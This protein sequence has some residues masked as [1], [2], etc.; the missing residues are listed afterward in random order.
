MIRSIAATMLLLAGCIAGPQPE[1]PTLGPDAAQGQTG[2]AGA[3]ADGG[4][5]PGRDAAA[6][7]D[8]GPSAPLAP[9]PDPQRV[10][11]PPIPRGPG[12]APSPAIDAG[13]SGD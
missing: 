10:R 5:S 12:P 8:G 6:D 9:K 4:V 1:P 3:I 2:D 13:G 11:L 7:I